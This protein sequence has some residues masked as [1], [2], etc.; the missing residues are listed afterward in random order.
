MADVYLTDRHTFGLPP[1]YDI[2][3]TFRL[4][5]A[6]L[7]R[8]A[9][10]FVTDEQRTTS[11]E[12]DLVK[13]MEQV[14]LSPE[15]E[16][17]CAT[18]YSSPYSNGNSWTNIEPVGVDTA[19][20]VSRNFQVRRVTPEYF[21]VFRVKDKEGN[22]ILPQLQAGGSS[23]V[24]SADMEA[25]FFG[26]QSGVG[27]KVKVGNSTEE[28]PVAAVSQPLRPT[29]YEVSRPFYYAVVTGNDFTEIAGS[30]GASTVELC[31]RMKKDYTPDE[32]NIFLESISDRLI[33]NNLYVYG[34]KKFTLQREEQI[35]HYSNQIK[36]RMSLMAFM[37]VNVFF[38]VAGT[39]WLRTQYRRGEIGLRMAM[40]S[41][42]RG[43]YGFMNVPAVI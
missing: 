4:K 5:L 12:E 16:E 8:M 19:N 20:L 9:P 39:F 22:D 10:G 24:I 14:R 42:R 7:N 35:R 28:T 6:V 32:M 40:G 38:G 30:F 43:V 11:E 34:S 23:L 41:S 33:V 29:D 27:R 3:N 26:G 2:T 36:I 37:L 1:G 15:V 17:V 21:T 18:F 13:L 25:Q 31:V